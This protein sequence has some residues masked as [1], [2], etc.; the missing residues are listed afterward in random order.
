M[1]TKE[2]ADAIALWANIGTLIALALNIVALYYA[3]RQLWIGRRS[4]SAGALL[5]LNESFRQA[6]FVFVQASDD[7]SKQHALSDVMNLLETACVIF[8]DG[9]FVGKS[10]KLLEDYLCHVFISI[11]HSADARARI[12]KMFTTGHTFDHIIRFLEN[13]REL[14][15]EDI[16]PIS[17][18]A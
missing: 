7:D 14:L 15:K 4:G 13:R 17:G 9:L 1:F 12:P 16:F 5:T 3:A 2:T 8:E 18:S 6:W 10:G 11:Q